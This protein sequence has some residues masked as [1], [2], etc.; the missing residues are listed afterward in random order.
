M[1]EARTPLH[2][3][4]I[5][6]NLQNVKKH[7]GCGVNAK[8]ENG[9]TALML[10]SFHKRTDNDIAIV[11]ILLQSGADIYVVDRHGDNALHYAVKKPHKEIVNSLLESGMD[12]N[13][14]DGDGNTPLIAAAQEGYE[15]IVDILIF[16]HADIH[17]RTRDNRNALY[18]ALWNKHDDTAKYL[19]NEYCGDDERWPELELA[20]QENNTKVVYLLL[21]FE[22]IH[23][24]TVLKMCIMNAQSL[25]NKKESFKTHIIENDL[26]VCMVTETWFKKAHKTHDFI[27]NGYSGIRKDRE[28]NSYSKKKDVGGGVLIVFKTSLS[29]KQIHREDCQSFEFVEGVMKNHFS[30]RLICMYWP[31]D[32]TNSP[33]VLQTSVDNFET[34]INALDKPNNVIIAGDFNVPLEND[35]SSM[36]KHF[37]DKLKSLGLKQHMEEFTRNEAILDLL[38]TD[39]AKEINDIKLHK[40]YKE[41]YTEHPSDHIP[42]HFKVVVQ[43]ARYTNEKFK[44]AMEAGLLVS[45]EKGYTQTARLLLNYGVDID[46]ADTSGETALHRATINGKTDTVNCLLANGCDVDNA[47]QDGCTAL[48]LASKHGH[49]EIVELL[50]EQKVKVDKCNYKKKGALHFA[51]L[52]GWKIIVR[53]LIDNGCDVDASTSGGD[54]ALMMGCLKGHIEIVQMLIIRK[55]DAN[56]KNAFGRTALHFAV[57]NGWKIIVRCLLDNGCDV[58]V[59]TSGGYTALMI[60]CFE[61]HIEIV[62]LLITCKADVNKKDEFGRTALHFA[63]LGDDKTVAYCLLK[64]RSDVNASTLWGNTPLMLGCRE[65]YTEMVRLLITG[66]ANVNKKKASG[67]TALHVAVHNDRESPAR[68]LLNSGRCCV[69]ACTSRG[70]TALMLGCE[71]GYI[72]MVRLLIECGADMNRNNNNGDT[73]LMLGCKKGYIEMVRLL[74]ECGAD[75]NKNNKN[76]DTALDIAHHEGYS[77]IVKVLEHSMKDT[78]TDTVSMGDTHTETVSMGDTHTE[79]VSMGDTHTE[80]VSMGETSLYTAEQND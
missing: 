58:D 56:K 19:L 20:C 3:A 7:I 31:P 49:I 52:N 61:G 12:V 43:T 26:D 76:G 50:I 16:H 45:C 78:H 30:C 53:C 10:V 4:V 23:E 60:G 25:N 24:L 69:N 41:V 28:D 73:A 75:I 63:V 74:I 46:T 64:H 39:D 33:S 8:D 34:H 35:Q 18:F 38:I 79:T 27:P 5:E 9:R 62:Q 42:I 80:T 17:I 66:K 51:V 36:T 77:D 65:G 14:R 68:C 70:N 6:G 54:T 55:A 71:K 32:K 37:N 13:S 47:R 44:K 40:Q 11:E 21:D 48:L 59:S 2:D 1:V 15:D 22:I 72:E 29:V 67:L 57:L